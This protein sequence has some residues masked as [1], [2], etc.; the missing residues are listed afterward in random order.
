METVS[1]INNWKLRIRREAEYACLL[2]GD[3]E[4]ARRYRTI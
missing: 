1:G 4:M 3:E 2:A